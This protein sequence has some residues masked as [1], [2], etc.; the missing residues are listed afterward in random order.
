MYDIC[1]KI[2]GCSFLDYQWMYA[3][4]ARRACSRVLQRDTEVYLF[5]ENRI[6]LSVAGVLLVGRGLADIT[7]GVD[8][9]VRDS[10]LSVSWG[11]PE[12]KI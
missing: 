7:R 2:C 1:H 8:T 11:R 4:V 10:A 9:R 12:K 5:S 3:C 6:Q